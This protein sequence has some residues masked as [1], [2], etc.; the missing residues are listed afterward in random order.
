[1]PEQPMTA[2]QVTEAYKAMMDNI[3]LYLREMGVSERLADDMLATEPERVHILTEAELK[4]YGLADVDPAERQR[5]AIDNE[6][7]DVWEANQ[8]GVG[9]ARVHSP[10]GSWN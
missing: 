9:S 4:S 8:L 3:H 7:R 10:K 5:R 1:M 6:A 2:K